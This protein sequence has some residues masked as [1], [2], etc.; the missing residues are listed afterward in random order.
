MLSRIIMACV[1]AV[2]AFL[3]CIFVGGL[4]ATTGVPIAAFVGGFLVQWA[5]LISILVFLAYF[6]G[7]GSLP[8]PF[9]RA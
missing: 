4:L 5:T 7:G 1:A 3:V 8:N 9:N 6:F 2:V